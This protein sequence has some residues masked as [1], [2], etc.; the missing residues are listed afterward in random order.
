MQRCFFEFGFFVA[1]PNLRASVR[2]HLT[3]SRPAPADEPLAPEPSLD[4]PSYI[5]DGM[6]SVHHTATMATA[7]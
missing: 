7:P 1:T 6:N 3:Y 4:E 5:R 2:A